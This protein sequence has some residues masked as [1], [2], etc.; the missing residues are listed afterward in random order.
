[1]MKDADLSRANLGS[2][3]LSRVDVEKTQF[4]ANVGLLKR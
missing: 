2:A 3:N 1:M 4:G